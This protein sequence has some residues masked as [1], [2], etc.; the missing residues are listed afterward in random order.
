ML[1]L[2]TWYSL[3]PL[4]DFSHSHASDSGPYRDDEE[5]SLLGDLLGAA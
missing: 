1:L 4:L 3:V 2:Y 5:N